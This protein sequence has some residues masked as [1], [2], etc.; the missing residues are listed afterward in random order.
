MGYPELQVVPRATER[1][2][3]EA[4][5][6]DMSYLLTHW[7]I[8]LSGLS[9]LAVGLTDKRHQRG[10]LS[11]KEV[12]DANSIAAATT[13]VGA[14]W[15]IG[16]LLLGAQRPYYTGQRSVS[17]YSSKDERSVLLR[18][19][20]A[21]EALE[22]PARIMRVL[23]AVAVTTNLAVNVASM[24]HANDSGKAGAG[25]A[26]LVSLLPLMFEDHNIMVYDKHLEYKKKIYAPIKSASIVYDPY[27]RSYT[28]VTQLTWLF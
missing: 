11:A 10:D 14:G 21:E 1:L 3:M 18:E 2:Y 17:K 24:I 4:K 19:R 23:E 16:G 7:P 28:P 15:L 9:T 5:A 20:L 26:A 22:R 12:R 6:E 8:E 25:L 27:S 13:A